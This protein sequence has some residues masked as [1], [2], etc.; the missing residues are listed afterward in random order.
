MNPAAAHPLEERPI[1]RLRTVDSPWQTLSTSRSELDL[2]LT[3]PTG[4]SFRWR[5]LGPTRKGEYVGVLGQR[6]VCPTIGL[7]CACQL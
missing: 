3:L 1:K 6:V 2:D 7:C 5:P 4:Q